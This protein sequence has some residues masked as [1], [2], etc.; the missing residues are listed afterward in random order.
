[1]D[2]EIPYAAMEKATDAVMDVRDASPRRPDD[3]ES[4]DVTRAALEAAAPL[5][6]AA[7]L[8]RLIADQANYTQSGAFRPIVLVHRCAGLRAQSTESAKEA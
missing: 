1:M 2:I 8:E 4:W 6:V 7:E 3:A 5:I